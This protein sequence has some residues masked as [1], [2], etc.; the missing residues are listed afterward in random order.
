[1]FLPTAPPHRTRH[2]QAIHTGG[3]SH[4]PARPPCVRRRTR[5]RAIT[6]QQLASATATGTS[7]TAQQSDG[8]R[9]RWPLTAAGRRFPTRFVSQKKIKHECELLF[10]ASAAR[11]NCVSQAIDHRERLQLRYRCSFRENS[12]GRS[13][14]IYRRFAY[15]KCAAQLRAYMRPIIRYNTSIFCWYYLPGLEAE[16]RSVAAKRHGKRRVS[17]PKRDAPL[18]L[19]ARPESHAARE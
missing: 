19:A 11:G 6:R 13:P 12:C 18:P 15:P 4:H 3:G 8:F 7:S 14:L 5:G 16:G 1:M 17:T 10:C 9:R 2:H